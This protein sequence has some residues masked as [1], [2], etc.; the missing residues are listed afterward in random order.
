MTTVLHPVP[1]AFTAI[2]LT[3]A[4]GFQ[5]FRQETI[6]QINWIP[7][8]L[9]A[10]I[11]FIVSSYL[12]FRNQ[13]DES[14]RKF[15]WFS[16]KHLFAATAI[17]LL[18]IL[19]LNQYH[20]WA[21]R[22]MRPFGYMA[23]KKM[24]DNGKYLLFAQAINSSFDSI[25]NRTSFDLRMFDNKN[26]KLS[27]LANRHFQETAFDSEGNSCMYET[28]LGPLSPG[29][30][31][32][33]LQD[34]KAGTTE[35]I[36]EYAKPLG[37]TSS[38]QALYT[39]LAFAENPEKAI[40]RSF[41]FESPQKMYQSLRLYDRSKRTSSLIATFP[42]DVDFHSHL[43]KDY[44]CAL[45]INRN[46]IWLINCNQVSIK[47]LD[48]KLEN[49]ANYYIS[50]P[51]DQEA[52][53]LRCSL[54]SDYDQKTYFVISPTGEIKHLNVPRSRLICAHKSGTAL[55]RR[56]LDD[57][58]EKFEIV[59]LKED[60]STEIMNIGE[61]RINRACFSTS[62]RY[63]ATLG[64]EKG[65]NTKWHFQVRDLQNPEK[66]LEV[67]DQIPVT[68]WPH[69]QDSFEFDAGHVICRIDSSDFTRVNPLFNAKAIMGK[70]ESN[71][72]D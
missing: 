65:E 61:Q 53:V 40:S 25:A 8:L 56:D 48:L 41:I 14:S 49:M 1:S 12:H 34:I 51:F 47:K 72:Q 35:V 6:A 43:N 63:L 4:L 46:N 23:V 10:I 27:P 57:M 60:G 39:R 21:N 7:Y 2:G 58:G 30:T 71:D 31:R 3:W 52:M 66:I 37:F 24:T 22:N 36:D 69:Q 59:L 64:W 5:G 32:L 9:F 38:G 33:I 62:G 15:L 55:F 18:S 45:A 44:N 19:T 67:K 28:D 26:A 54:R 17:F 16:F 50:R 29:T 70:E 13:P 68:I 11:I 42:A 20:E